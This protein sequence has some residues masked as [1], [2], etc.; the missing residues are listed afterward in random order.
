MSPRKLRIKAAREAA[1]RDLTETRFLAS[2]EIRWPEGTDNNDKAAA[3]RDLRDSGQIVMQGSR[4]TACYRLTG[5]APSQATSQEAPRGPVRTSEDS[6]LDFLTELPD[7]LQGQ[8]QATLVS[9]LID[10][11]SQRSQQS[12]QEAAADIRKAVQDGFLQA[13]RRRFWPNTIKSP[14]TERARSGFYADARGTLVG[15]HMV[16]W[17][18]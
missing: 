1:L 17:P 10:R 15:H 6:L 13:E 8:R 2:R 4:R 18:A 14:V 9:D 7:G 3:L 5:A 11:W 16:A 12:H